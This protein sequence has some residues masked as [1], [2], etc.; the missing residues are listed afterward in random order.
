MYHRNYKWKKN[1]KNT[2]QWSLTVEQNILSLVII[3]ILE[4]IPIV[5]HI[6]CVCVY[7]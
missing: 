5:Y 2:H 3:I 7:V 1:D 4:H 6:V